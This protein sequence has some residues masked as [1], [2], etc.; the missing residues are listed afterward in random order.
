MTLQCGQRE[1]AERDEAASGLVATREARVGQAPDP[2][3]RGARRAVVGSA[4]G[5]ATA[6]PA[7]PRCNEQDGADERRG[8]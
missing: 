5:G 4:R 2:E 7:E 8:S 3:R 6:G 1:S